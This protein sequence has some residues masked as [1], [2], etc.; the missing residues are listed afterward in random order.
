[1]RVNTMLTAAL[2]ALPLAQVAGE[3]LKSGCQPGQ[4]MP[5]FPVHDVT[6]KYK[7]DA[8]VCYI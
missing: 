4:G 8:A 1:M 5:A 2:L 7:K 6:G 3:E